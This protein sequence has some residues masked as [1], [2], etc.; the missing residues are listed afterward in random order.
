MTHPRAKIISPLIP[1]FLSIAILST[2]V[3][4]SGDDTSNSGKDQYPDSLLTRLNDD[5]QNVK[6]ILVASCYDCHSAKTF[7]PWYHSLPGVG[8]YLDGHIEHAREELDMTD[9]FPFAGE[10]GL[11]A[12]LSDIKKEIYEGEMPLFSY[13]LMHWGTEVTG[14]RRD[15]LFV[16]IDASLKALQ[17][18]ERN[19][20]AVPAAS[21]NSD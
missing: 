10:H 9:D 18:Y 12:A 20:L 1:L 17:A 8:G 5:Y 11:K 21:E 3:L 13:R 6:H 2:G 19:R 14:S 15:S 16:W 4:G 7:Y